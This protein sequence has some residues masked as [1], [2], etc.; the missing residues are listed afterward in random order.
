MLRAR[1]KWNMEELARRIF[2]GRTSLSAVLAGRRI[3][4][5]TWRKL[6]RVLSKPEFDCARKFAA[7]RLAVDWCFRECGSLPAPIDP[8]DVARF[9]L[10]QETRK[11]EDE[12]RL[13]KNVEQFNSWLDQQRK[14][15][16]IT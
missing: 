3:G 5:H 2:A 12:M 15:N 10:G 4:Q 8:K 1:T 9:I 6:A 11:G 16:S 7:N 14:I 13:P